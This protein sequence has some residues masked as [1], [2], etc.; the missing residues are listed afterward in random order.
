M[1]YLM[2]YGVKGQKWGVRRYQNEDGTLTEA[3]KARYGGQKEYHSTRFRNLM[4][5][6]ANGIL[7]GYGHGRNLGE[8]RADAF[9]K[10]SKKRMRKVY[11]L[12]ARGKTA[13]AEKYRERAEKDT[14]RAEAQK[15]QNDDRK[16]YD[17]HTSTGKMLAQNLLLT[18]WGAERYRNARARGDSRGRAAVQGL[19]A[20]DV[21]AGTIVNRKASKQVYGEATWSAM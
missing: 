8:A 1:A 20:H 10:R 5:G 11:K 4:T 7:L 14:R 13:R 17:R 2:H 9:E 18:G 6:R 16:A 19:L 15:A 21:I 3:G 12:E